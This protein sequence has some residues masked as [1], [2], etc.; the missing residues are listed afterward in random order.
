VVK[1]RKLDKAD[2]KVKYFKTEFMRVLRELEVEQAE[3]VK[4]GDEV[5]KQ[6]ESTLGK[7][8]GED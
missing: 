8:E 2:P 1:L 5:G 6:K 4:G 7:A 3:Q